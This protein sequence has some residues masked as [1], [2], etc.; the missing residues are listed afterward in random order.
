LTKE[1]FFTKM[2]TRTTSHV[3]R[4]KN[5]CVPPVETSRDFI[6]DVSCAENE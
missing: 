2:T 5:S 4:N 3:T 6:R 1:H